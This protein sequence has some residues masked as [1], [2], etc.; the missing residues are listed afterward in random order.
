MTAD[1]ELDRLSRLLRR[2][3]R[4]IAGAI[5]AVSVWFL[6]AWARGAGES[7]AFSAIQVPTAPATALLA[8]ILALG[9]IARA[10]P[11]QEDPSAA[12]L[13][14]PATA[15]ALA[16]WLG[17]AYVAG[18]EV[19][20]ERWLAGPAV[21]RDGVPLGRISVITASLFAVIAT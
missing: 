8:L 18:A 7:L 10:R 20:L 4:W 14:L 5:A 16:A 12:A 6:L 2:A 19:P 9:I 13:L 1:D 17:I 3:S 21:V 15:L 11:H